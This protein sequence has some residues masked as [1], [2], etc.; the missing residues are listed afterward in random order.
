MAIKSARTMFSFLALTLGM[1]CMLSCG[2]EDQ[3]EEEQKDTRTLSISPEETTVSHEASQLTLSLKVNFDYNVTIDVDWVTVESSSNSS[4]VLAIEANPETAEREAKIKV[5]D[6]SD[7]YYFKSVKVTQNAN[8][9]KKV[10]LS[11][12][13]K[14]A[15]DE[16]KALLANLWAIADKGFM[17]GH[18]DDLWYGRHWYNVQGKS[19]TK[20]VCG[21]YPAVFSVDFAPIIDDRYKSNATENEIR[22]RV[23]LEAKERGEV[24]VACLHL[25]NPLTIAE[26]EGKYPEGTSWDNTKCVDQILKDGTDVHKRYVTW[27]DRLAEFANDLKDSKG[28]LIPIILRPYHEMTQSWS[29]WGTSACTSEEYI[30]LWQWTVKYLRDVKGVHN[31]LYA[32]SPQMDGKYGDSTRSRLLTRWPGDD[33]VDFLGMDC[34]H[35]LNYG[36][37]AANIEVMQ[38]L[39]TEKMKPCG[40]T[41]TGSEAFTNNDYWTRYILEPAAGKGL[42]MVVM[43]RN[44]Y[45][46]SDSDTHYFSVFPGHPSEEDFRTFYKDEHTLFSADLPDM[47]SMPANY[48]IK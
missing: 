5:S 47:Y 6:K 2:P 4:I 20:D 13:D 38:K 26:N 28:K 1:A 29:W 48:E 12:V 21:D 11:I 25:D 35:G 16:T 22:R 44:K 36:A 30:E 45:V 27:M 18:H 7:K 10:K 33:Y 41:E 19:D 8:P 37:F 23:I 15:T 39:A 46:S 17:F 32:V 40:V 31:F 3:P 43:W 9:V 42:S 14:E 34:Y 24:I